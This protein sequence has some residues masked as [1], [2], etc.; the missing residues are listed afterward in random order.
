M[1][2]LYRGDCLSV[3]KRLPA[4]AVDAVITD[5]PYGMNWNVNSRRFSG[6]QSGAWRYRGQGRDDWRDIKGDDK[7]FDPEPWLQ[8][9]KA[10]LWGSNHFA[11]R[12]PVGTTLVWIKKDDSLFGSFLS[13]AEVGFMKGGHGVY[14][15]RR[16]FATPT[17]RFEGGGK[18]LHPNQKPIALMRWCIER[19]KLK[20]GSTILDPYMGSGTVGVAAIQLGFNYIGIEIDPE[21]HAI[22]KRRIRATAAQVSPACVS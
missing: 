13:D 20:A 17:R 2:K 5:P 3:L 10:I 4:G 15:F 18:S 6:G 19:L 21:Y 8:F 7:P 16:N 22:A 14:C 12:L 1:V 11:G 9:P